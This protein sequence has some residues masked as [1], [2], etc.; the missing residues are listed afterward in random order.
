[1]V[2]YIWAPPE[3]L[4]D[5]PKIRLDLA[6]NLSRYLEQNVENMTAVDPYRVEEYLED[7]RATVVSA[8]GVG[9][10]FDADMV[11]HAS[12]LSFSTR[13]PGMAHF[14]RGRLTSSISVIDLTPEHDSET[15]IPLSEVAIV[16]PE[17][18]PVGFSDATP[19]QVRQA[20][21]ETFAV[22]VGRKF[23]EWERPLDSAD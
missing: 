8:A 22:E 10:H 6:G 21:Y 4:W 17:E 23:H 13:D 9:K 11:V 3:T 12:L 20:T 2:V 1:V 16:V 14:Y 18:G 7:A 15:P 5:Y 19:D